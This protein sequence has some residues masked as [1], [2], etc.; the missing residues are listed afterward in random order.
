MQIALGET[1]SAVET[2]LEAGSLD[3]YRERTHQYLMQAYAATGNKAEAI[4]VYHRFGKL[5]AQDL[6]S[7]P[8]PEIEALYL[9][10]LD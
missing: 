9:K 4:N 3:P 5:L 7:D 6:G 10:L 2:A 8:S 1:E